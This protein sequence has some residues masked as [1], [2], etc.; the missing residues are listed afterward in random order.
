MECCRQRMLGGP[1]DETRARAVRTFFLQP[2]SAPTHNYLSSPENSFSALE[3][4]HMAA[5]TTAKTLGNYASGN[6]GRVKE[7]LSW[8]ESDNPGV[9]T[10]LARLLNAGRLGGTGRF[11]IL[12]VDQGFE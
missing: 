11:V 4:P 3:A 9:K 7:I 12:P 8:Y 2:P 5:G 10:N 1:F 6:T